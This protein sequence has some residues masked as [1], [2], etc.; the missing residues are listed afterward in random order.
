MSPGRCILLTGG[1][2]LIGGELFPLLLARPGNMVW[3]LARP[4][5]TLDADARLLARIRRGSS[6][7]ASTP[8][9]RLVGLTGDLTL[10]GLGMTPDERRSVASSVDLIVHCAA[11]TSF[12]RDECCRRINVEGMTHLIRFA[13]QCRKAPLFVHVSTATVCGVLRDRCVPEDWPCDPA[14]EHYNE[15]TRT[16]ALAENMLRD[17]G[18]RH[19]ILRPS[20]TVSA[21]IRDQAFAGAML[22]FLP[23][24]EQLDAVPIDPGGCLDVVT[25][26]FVAKAIAAIIEA[27]H[28]PHDCYHLSAGREALPLLRAARFL[29]E[30]YGR[31]RPLE[32]VPPSQWTREMHRRFIGTPE[33]R[34]TFSALKHYL[35]FLNMNVSFDNRRL[36]ELL[37]ENMPPIE[38]FE[39]YAGEL[40]ELMSA[41]LAQSV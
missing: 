12:I 19:L 26:A 17:S 30:F 34:K 10:D 9:H 40:L 8:W 2:G 29:D 4:Q 35:P 31:V 11:E 33:Q 16:K 6:T 41:N 3:A 25:V 15:Y 1:T 7:G 14:G 36:K 24:L 28:L 32:L 38:P 5:G 37:G 23:L 21:G 18:L 39:S 13:R 27:D 20:I 22:W